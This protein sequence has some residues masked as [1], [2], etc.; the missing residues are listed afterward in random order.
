MDQKVLGLLEE[1]K[2]AQPPE[3]I[4]PQSSPLP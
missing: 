2:K 1:F 3:N 4:P